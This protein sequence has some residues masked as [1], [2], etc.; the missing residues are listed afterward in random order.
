MKILQMLPS[1]V[2]GMF[3]LQVHAQTEMPNGFVKAKLVLP[4]ST[5]VTGYVK[6]HIKK[7]ASLIFL[8]ETGAVKKTYSGDEIISAEIG[9]AQFICIRGDFFKIV[10]TGELCFLQKCSDASRKPTYNGTEALFISG[11]PGKPGDYFIYANRVK[12]L[13][14]VSNKTFASVTASSFAG[15]TAAIEKAGAVQGDIARL[16]EAVII[17]NNL[18]GK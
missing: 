10:C 2:L 1:L 16:G 14:L 12:A 15:C 9:A 5:V 6:D 13:K 3:F 17:Y 18:A 7:D 11:T 8:S 4:D